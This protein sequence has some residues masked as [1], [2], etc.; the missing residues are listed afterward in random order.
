MIGEQ[1]LDR[2]AGD[3]FFVAAGATHRF[4]NFSD[5]FVTW[6]AFDGPQAGE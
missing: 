5:D 2:K 3:A 6:A 1:R 4:E